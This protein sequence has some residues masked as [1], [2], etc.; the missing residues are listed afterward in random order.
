MPAQNPLYQEVYQRIKLVTAGAKMRKISVKRLALLVV[1]IIAAQD[2]VLAKIA[3]E[4]L[5]LKL[6]KATAKESLERT[7]ERILSDVKLDPKAWYEPALRTSVDWEQLLRGSQQVVL[8]LDESSKEDEV[9]LLR[10]GLPYWGHCLPVVWQIWAQNQPL[11]E[12]EGYWSRIDALLRAASAVVPSLLKVTVL[13]DR[14]YDVPNF[15]DRLNARG[16]HW[17]VRYKA[18]GAG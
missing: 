12:A 13:A 8:V 4:L 5:S 10:M 18:N 2:V 11:D 17:T 3:D 6:T 15:V 9:H 1:G 16:W 7:L 14:A